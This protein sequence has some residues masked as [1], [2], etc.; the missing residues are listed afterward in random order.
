MSNGDKAKKEQLLQLVQTAIQHD[1]Q[2]REQYQIGEKFRFVRDR[3][4]AL[5][6]E[7]E[8]DIAQMQEEIV[9]K[10]TQVK[11]DDMLVYVHLFNAQGIIFQ[12]WHKML[13]PSVFYEYSVNRPIYTDKA[14]IE[15]LVRSRQNRAQ[16]GILTV[17]IKKQDILPTP[18]DEEPA[19]DAN[20]TLLVKIREGSLSINRMVSFTHQEQDYV[21]NENGQV[22]K[23]LEE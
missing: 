10:T 5:A 11:E 13:A 7:I 20:G 12:S 9:K 19:K 1:T 2:L 6:T 8:T 22:T 17:A 15:S 21:I 3:L 14:A 23:K 4:T 16:H 18:A